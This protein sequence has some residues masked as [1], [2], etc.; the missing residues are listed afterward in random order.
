MLTHQQ[1]EE[2]DAF[3]QFI[4]CLQQAEFWLSIT[5]RA[6]PEPDLLCEHETRGAIAFELVSLTDPTIAAIQAAGLG[7]KL[8][9]CDGTFVTRHKGHDPTRGLS[10]H[11]WGVSMDINAKWNAYGQIPAPLGAIG[12]TREFVSIFEALGFAWGGYFSHPYEDGMH[13]E[14]ARFDL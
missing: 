2:H 13:F 6:P 8:L 10:S 7:S 14:L 9:S 11:S 12:S 5:S 1:Q 4:D 3:R